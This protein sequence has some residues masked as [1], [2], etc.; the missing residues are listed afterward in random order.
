MRRFYSR[1]EIDCDRLGLQ[2][3]FW[4]RL[5]NGRDRIWQIDAL[6]TSETGGVSLTLGFSD[7]RTATFQTVFSQTLDPSVDVMLSNAY[8][9]WMDA[10]WH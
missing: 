9:N 6:Q 1:F 7:D 3:V 4:N 10:T 8:L 5:G 2:R